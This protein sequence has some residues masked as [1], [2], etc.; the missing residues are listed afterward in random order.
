[1]NIIN[2]GVLPAAVDHP[3][4]S[5]SRCLG[6]H[7]AWAVA[8]QA[9]RTLC[10]CQAVAVAVKSCCASSC[11]GLTVYLTPEAAAAGGQGIVQAAVQA[12]RQDRG[13]LGWPDR[14]PRA[15]T[16][17]AAAA[18]AG[19]GDAVGAA[20][21]VATKGGAGQVHRHCV[22]SGSDAE[23]EDQQEVYVDEYLRPP[24]VREVLQPAVAYLTVPALPRG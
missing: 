14:M 2:S 9:W 8:A 6:D 17:A 19:A 3:S 5:S 23:G 4:S 12:V 20:A 21:A 10:S 18:A 22:Q 1:M 16:A 24:A 15:L 7:L 11:L 13:L